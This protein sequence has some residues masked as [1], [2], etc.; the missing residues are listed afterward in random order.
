V[1][2]AHLHGSRFFSIKTAAG[3]YA[4]VARGIPFASGLVLVFDAETGFL[5]AVLFDNAY[6]TELRTGAAGALAADLLAKPEVGRVGLLGYGRMLG[7][8]GHPPQ[9]DGHKKCNFGGGMRE[10]LGKLARMATAALAAVF[11]FRRLDDFDT[12]WHLAAGRWIAGYGA[13]PS[14]D[15]LSH[16][17]R[18]HPWIDLQWGFDL[19]VYALHAAGGPILLGLAGALGFSVA[20]VLVLRLVRPHLGEA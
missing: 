5:R 18:D 11:A 10:I 12:W 3:F 8:A 16:T 7:I 17:V 19:A 1:K 13:V 20:V 2:G 6:L 15:T 4:N 9:T 14:T